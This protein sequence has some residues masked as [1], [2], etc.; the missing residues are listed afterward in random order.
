MTDNGIDDAA[1]VA[2]GDRIPV[3]STKLSVC[4]PADWR[5]GSIDEFDSSYPDGIRRVI[6]FFNTQ[7]SDCREELPALQEFYD[8]IKENENI[9]MVCISRSQG[10]SGITDYWKMN[11]LTLPYSAQ[12]DRAIYDMFASA[13][14]PRIYMVDEDGV[15]RRVFNDSYLPT[16][17]ELTEIIGNI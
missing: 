10:E 13:G 12:D 6:V 8:G 9:A 15:V 14:I 3:F 2:E 7:C 11:G 4:D 16:A 5:Y 17:A 1:A